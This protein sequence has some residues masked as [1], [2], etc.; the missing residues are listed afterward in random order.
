M[1]RVTAIAIALVLAGSTGFESWPVSAQGD[2]WTTLFDGK[3]LKGWNLM[4]N[5][6]WEVVDG[7][8]Q[9]TSGNG[10]LV[11]TA[12]YGDVQI[13]VEFWADDDANSGVFFR[14]TDLKTIN[15][16][17]A[18][19]AQIF[20]KRPDPEFRTGALTFI[21]KPAATINTG[22]KWNTYDITARGSRLTVTL[23]GTQMVD[24]Q[25]TKFARGPIALQ[26]TAGVVK[27]RNVRV[28]T[29]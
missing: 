28:R 13:V 15:A 12:S 4:G 27:F 22:G 8:V 14:C 21:A 9:A 7:V 26:R 1:T 17:T 18:Y 20:D 24:V 2:G 23:N 16:K 29:L 10:N 6:N 3:T 25:D 5:A 19:E 11:S